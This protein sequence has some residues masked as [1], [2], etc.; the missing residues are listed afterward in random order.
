[1]KLDKMDEYLEEQEQ[2]TGFN[3]DL[4]HDM[5]HDSEV[6]RRYTEV[7]DKIIADIEEG[8]YPWDGIESIDEYKDRMMEIWRQ[9]MDLDTK[10]IIGDYTAEVLTNLIREDKYF[11]PENKFF[12][13]LPLEGEKSDVKDAYFKFMHE[14]RDG[15]TE[16]MLVMVYNSGSTILFPS[17]VFEAAIENFLNKLDGESEK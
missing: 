14:D 3:F 1:M 2:V 12:Q 8:E 13:V 16:M 11:D 15:L 9:R 17:S 7:S 10:F 5:Y 4:I 6:E